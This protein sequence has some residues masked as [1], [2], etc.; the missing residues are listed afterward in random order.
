M[1]R[2]KLIWSLTARNPSH[3]NISPP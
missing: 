2:S 3:L 1:R